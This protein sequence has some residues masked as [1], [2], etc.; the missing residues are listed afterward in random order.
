[1]MQA[2]ETLGTRPA[3]KGLHL[4]LWVAQ[5]LL[6]LAFGMAGLMKLATPYADLAAQ[7]AWALQ[8]PEALVKVIGLVE[9]LGALGV[10]LPAATR[11]KPFLTPLAAAGFVVIM[12]LGGALHASLG[13]PPISNVV[14]GALAAFVAWGRVKKAPIAPR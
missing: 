4:G 6:A 12:V 5:G 10:L 8:T 7:Q 2:T 13:E 11:I 9:L 1:M 14:L 3:G